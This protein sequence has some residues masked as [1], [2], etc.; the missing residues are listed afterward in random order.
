MSKRNRESKSGQRRQVEP[1][2]SAASHGK[3]A[4]PG[5]LVE[6]SPGRRHDQDQIVKRATRGLIKVEWRRRIRATARRIVILALLAAIG[7]ACW[8]AVKD[9]LPYDWFQSIWEDLASKIRPLIESDDA[10][11]PAGP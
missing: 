9:R 8:Y 2:S 7:F 1:V 11:A 4:D 6:P 3:T 10:A 5:T